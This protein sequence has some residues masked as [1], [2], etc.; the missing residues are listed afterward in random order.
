MIGLWVA[1]TNIPGLAQ[2][3]K[4]S[5]HAVKAADQAPSASPPEERIPPETSREQDGIW[6][7]ACNTYKS[8]A[9]S[10]ADSGWT[11]ERGRPVPATT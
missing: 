8:P 3:S 11:A 6:D 1:I 10:L 9:C 5:R 2:H 7:P 4:A